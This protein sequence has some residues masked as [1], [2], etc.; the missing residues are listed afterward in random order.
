MIHLSIIIVCVGM[1]HVGMLQAKP[2]SKFSQMERGI[3]LFI[4]SLHTFISLPT[5]IWT[6]PSLRQLNFLVCVN[7]LSSALC[8]VTYLAKAFFHSWLYLLQF[9]PV[10]MHYIVIKYLRTQY[11]DAVMGDR[12]DEQVKL[13]QCQE[14]AEKEAEEVPESA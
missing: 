11:H 10:L 5:P 8:T 6:Q 7:L 3:Y 2:T 14:E 9:Y 12:V 4:I 13:P 1:L